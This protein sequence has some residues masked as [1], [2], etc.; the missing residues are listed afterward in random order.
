LEE[1]VAA[2]VKKTETNDRGI[3]CAD[4]ATPSIRKSWHYFA[5]KRR[6][7]GRHSSLADQSLG[8]FFFFKETNGIFHLDVSKS[9]NCSDYRVSSYKCISL[10]L[11]FQDG[12]GTSKCYMSECNFYINTSGTCRNMQ[13]LLFHYTKQLLTDS[14]RCVTPRKLVQATPFVNCI[15]EVSG[16]NLAGT[17]TTLRGFVVFLGSSRQILGSQFKLIHGCFLVRLF[18]LFTIINSFDAP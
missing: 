11:Y 6:S 9:S 7:L 1:I 8:G 13:T 2:P 17:S 3:R 18:L 5:N 12:I 16:S 15:Q 10:I 14:L 4:H